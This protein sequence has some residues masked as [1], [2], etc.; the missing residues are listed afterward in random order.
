MNLSGYVG[1]VTIF[2]HVLLTSRVRVRVRIRFSVWLVSCF[3]HVFVRLYAGIVTHR[4]NTVDYFKRVN[5]APDM[6]VGWD[7]FCRS[8]PVA[9]CYEPC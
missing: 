3:A 9:P 5:D 8:R 6:R 2:S 1:H 4:L 7:T